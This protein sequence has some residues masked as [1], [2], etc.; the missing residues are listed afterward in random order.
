MTLRIF[1]IFLGQFLKRKTRTSKEM[2][3]PQGR[4]TGPALHSKQALHRA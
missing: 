4:T 3:E 1:H 2:E